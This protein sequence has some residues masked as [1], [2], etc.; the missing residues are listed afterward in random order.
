VDY[1]AKDNLRFYVS[2]S[3]RKTNLENANTPNFPGGID[4]TDY[5][6]NSNHN[7]IAGVGIDWTVRPTLINQFH[8]GYMYQYSAFVIE[9]K[10]I[11][12]T[13]ISQ[14]VWSYGAGLYS[15]NG[16]YGSLGYPRLP[17][18]SFYPLLSANDN[19]NWQHGTHSMTVAGSWFRHGEGNGFL[20]GSH[21]GPSLRE[22]LAG[23]V[24][25]Q[26]GPPASAVSSE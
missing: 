15:N 21:V 9:N 1:N 25:G 8:A 24:D 14:Q 26:S 5:T 17:I 13:K 2:Y 11:D 3:Q 19:V 18:S 20:A 6:S 10:G 12:L 23:L 4:P 22:A 16:T 7:R